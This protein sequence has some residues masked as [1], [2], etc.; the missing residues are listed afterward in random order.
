MQFFA[1]V[2]PEIT[3]ARRK[4]EAFFKVFGLLTVPML[5]GLLAALF[6][7]VPDQTREIYRYY[8]SELVA[9]VAAVPEI[10]TWL[11]AWRLG[12]GAMEFR[13]FG[14]LIASIFIWMLARNLTL[15]FAPDSLQAGG[16][17]GV[18]LRWLPRICG[19]QIT[20]G[21]GIGCLIASGEVRIIPFG[22]EA[23]PSLEKDVADL[24]YV[25]GIGFLAFSA[26]LI[27][28]T[29]LRTWRRRKAVETSHKWLFSTTSIIV[30]LILTAASI[31]LFTAPWLGGISISA[32]QWL[33]APAIFGLFVIQIGY[34]ASLLSA[35]RER[36]GAPILSGLAVWAVLLAWSGLN[37]N[38]AIHVSS[39]ATKPQRP[40]LNVAFIDWYNAR[41]DRAAF[42]NA[43]KPYPVFMVSAAGGGLYAAAFTSATLARLQDQC[44]AF[45]QHTFAIS[46]VSGGGLG[47]ALFTTMLG[48]RKQVAATSL[49]DLASCAT[50]TFA[51]ANQVGLEKEAR[52][53][54]DWDFL[55]PIV[56]A[57][58]FPDFLQRFLPF[59]V[60]AFD[61]SRAFEASLDER[62]RAVQKKD[63]SGTD[64]APFARDYLSHWKAS[65]VAPA[66]V[67]NA[68][69]VDIGYRTVLAPFII[70][71]AVPAEYT[72]LKNFHQ[73]L[74]GDVSLGT[75]VGLTARFPWVM[76][77]ATV[78]QTG[79][80]PKMRLLD[81]GIFENS[82][83]DTISDML[84]ELRIF[85]VDPKLRLVDQANLPWVRFHPLIISGYQLNRVE[86]ATNFRGEALSPVTAMLSSRVQR[87]G[88]AS[89]RLFLQRGYNCAKRGQSNNCRPE[90]VR[91]F[92]LNHEDYRIPVG[93][94]LSKL[95]SNVIQDH[96]GQFDRCEPIP[97][98]REMF[99]ERTPDQTAQRLK[100]TRQEN[101]CSA[102][103][104]ISALRG[105]DQVGAN[106]CN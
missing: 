9:E 42:S 4:I 103:T 39:P 36:I 75:A 77:P 33:G 43:G 95:T 80:K 41:A 22:T 25:A 87:A 13:I 16:M 86:T 102:C 12:V 28:V 32:A 5:V 11:G 50:R 66:L 7:W 90:G 8:A 29:Y 83:V 60:A 98:I 84:T 105:Q 49:S 100:Y 88:M 99:T 54:L 45:A 68:T 48:D 64:C 17:R 57:G 78:A 47:A 104:V 94:Q 93:W 34:Y 1:E 44:P 2:R 6:L 26:L 101:N 20:A 81:G 79:N 15:V 82:G 53:F 63:C 97:T 106:L 92:V 52:N 96:I 21:A 18:A 55:A 85:E 10:K 31:V 67:L 14:L 23:L 91:F 70:A 76:P 59:P 72:A 19:A 62:W 51:M 65:G 89:Y 24:L 69:D 35:A 71:N 73:Y 30:F 74:D 46:G 58:L 3:V 27:L 61:R 37:E 56:G 38:H 40:Q